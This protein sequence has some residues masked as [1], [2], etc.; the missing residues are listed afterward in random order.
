ME[1]ARFLEENSDKTAADFKAPVVRLDGCVGTFPTGT[2]CFYSI[3]APVR[4]L[5]EIHFDGRTFYRLLMPI[6]RT[7]SEEEILAYVYANKGQDGAFRPALG[8]LVQCCVWLC[9]DISE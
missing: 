4:E 5:A 2:T 9:A 1:M 3:L 7:A 6:A 8:E